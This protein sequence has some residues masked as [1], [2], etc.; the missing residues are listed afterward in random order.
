MST[1]PTPTLCLALMGCLLGG[2]GP[3]HDA[4]VLLDHVS[5]LPAPGAETDYV[6]FSFDLEAPPVWVHIELESDEV[7]EMYGILAAPFDTCLL[8]VPNWYWQTDHANDAFVFLTESGTH[9]L[10]VYGSAPGEAQVHAIVTVVPTDELPINANAECS[11][12]LEQC[13]CTEDC[14]CSADL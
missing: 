11:L 8:Q 7:E 12:G 3:A 2:T 1:N 10:Y 5:D 13:A 6:G 14:N 9:N 4:I